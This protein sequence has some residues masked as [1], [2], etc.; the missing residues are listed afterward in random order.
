MYAQPTRTTHPSYQISAA[1]L[2][3]KTSLNMKARVSASF[4]MRGTPVLVG[5]AVRGI[6]CPGTISGPFLRVPA[7]H[8][9]KLNWKLPETP[10]LVGSHTYTCSQAQWRELTESG[11]CVWQ[12]HA[13]PMG[14]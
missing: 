8:M 14:P 3:E 1:M 13:M 12:V 7:Q 6:H 2:S 5:D 9:A 11:G 10:K 4:D